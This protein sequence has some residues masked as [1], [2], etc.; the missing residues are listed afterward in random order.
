MKTL[1]SIL[2]E[3]QITGI[4]EIV[5]M[6]KSQVKQWYKYHPDGDGWNDNLEPVKNIKDGIVRMGSNYNV[7]ERNVLEFEL[8]CGVTGRIQHQLSD[9]IHS[10]TSFIN[11]F[12]IY[13]DTVDSPYDGFKFRY[14]TS[15][16]LKDAI[17]YIKK[18]NK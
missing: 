5:K 10:K 1:S 6:I 15:P 9:G 18:L 11:G 3:S 7:G 2:C 12:S 17:N 4:E 14:T 16:E 8:W 13:L